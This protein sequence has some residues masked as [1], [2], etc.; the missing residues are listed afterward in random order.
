ME[1]ALGEPSSVQASRSKG[2]TA[3]SA[4]AGMNDS[5]QCSARCS[6]SLS[7]LLHPPLSSG[8]LQCICNEE[9]NAL[10]QLV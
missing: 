2:L 10:L 3:V 1:E 5:E 9:E 6:T 7:H 4:H 8:R